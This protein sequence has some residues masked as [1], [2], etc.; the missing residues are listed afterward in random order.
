MKARS[1]ASY[2][3]KL[4]SFLASTTFYIYFNQ[5]FEKIILA[6]FVCLIYLTDK[7]SKGFDFGL[8][9]GMILIDLQKIFDTIDH[10]ILLLKIP[11]SGFLPE[12][13]DWYKS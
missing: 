8:L 3:S 12:V 2:M 7:I 6:T 4:W 9:T 5:D 11:L 1:E 13:I 10:N